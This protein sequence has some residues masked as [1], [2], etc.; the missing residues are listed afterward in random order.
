MGKRRFDATF[1][2]LSVGEC[3]NVARKPSKVVELRSGISGTTVGFVREQDEPFCGPLSTEHIATWWLIGRELGGHFLPHF[4]HNPDQLCAPV[5]AEE[6]RCVEN[7]LNAAFECS[8]HVAYW[9]IPLLNRL[10]EARSA[11]YAIESQ[12]KPNESP[13][14]ELFKNLATQVLSNTADDLK[15]CPVIVSVPAWLSANLVALLISKYSFGRGGGRTGTISR[16]SMRDLLASPAMMAAWL[17]R[18]PAFNGYFAAELEELD[19]AS[20]EDCDSSG[21]AVQ[22][23]V[24][25]P[26]QE[27]RDTVGPMSRTDPSWRSPKGG[28]P[29]STRL[30]AMDPAMEPWEWN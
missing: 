24:A 8:Y 1:D 12:R 20:W 26:R 25:R 28:K 5:P 17:R 13:Q 2:G 9:L 6:S 21:A 18:R 4:G 7:L 29:R 30:A 22:C 19:A 15:S 10:E 27:D 11:W 3:R 14:L 23:V 16:K